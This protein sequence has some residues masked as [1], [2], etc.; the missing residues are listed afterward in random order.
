MKRA[1]LAARAQA[2]T[3]DDCERAVRDRP[4]D[5]QSYYCFT[6]AARGHGVYEQADRRLEEIWHRFPERS[7]ALLNL[8]V[9]EHDLGHARARE[10]YRQAAAA[11][12]SAHDDWG[13]VYADTG[14]A[15][16][17][18]TR[19]DRDGAEAELERAAAAAKRNGDPILSAYVLVTQATA[20]SD[21]G[22]PEQ[23]L[24]R[25]DRAKTLAFPSGPVYLRSSILSE[26]GV[27][28]CRRR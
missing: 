18:R 15:N 8:A 13:V 9:L 6:L 11:A 7:R 14:L 1:A 22:D 4:D 23:A 2:P 26:L 12:E 20:A 21:D 3:L 5:P 10:L 24:R 19:G 28:R 25:L 16:L 27:A 17:L